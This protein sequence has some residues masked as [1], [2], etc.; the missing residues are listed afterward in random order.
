[1][2]DRRDSPNCPVGK[3]IFAKRSH[4]N[5]PPVSPHC[6]KR[7]AVHGVSFDRNWHCDVSP[8]ALKR[9]SVEINSSIA[10]SLFVGLCVCS[11]VFSGVMRFSDASI[12]SSSESGDGERRFLSTIFEV[13]AF[14]FDFLGLVDL[15]PSSVVLS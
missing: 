15:T 4:F 2:S 1:M 14:T 10:Y 6:P 7:A 8:R 13:V 11:R 3:R 12:T 5:T 9:G